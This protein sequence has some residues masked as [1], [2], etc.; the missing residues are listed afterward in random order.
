MGKPWQTSGRAHS[1]WGG[2]RIKVRRGKRQVLGRLPGLTSLSN[3]TVSFVSPSLA[4]SLS[5]SQGS[6]EP[7]PSDTS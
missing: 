1:S 7:T 5:N 2:V 4:P 3:D 6:L